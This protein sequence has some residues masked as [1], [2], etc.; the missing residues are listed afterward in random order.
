MT[1]GCQDKGR[2]AEDEGASS[3]VATHADVGIGA[4]DEVGLRGAALVVV[5]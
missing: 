4:D 3:G 1:K 2:D 5:Y